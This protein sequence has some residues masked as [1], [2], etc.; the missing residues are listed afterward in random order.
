MQPLSC[1]VPCWVLGVVAMACTEV[2][3]APCPQ[4]C[5]RVWHLFAGAAAPFRPLPP[6]GGSIIVS[7]DGL[8]RL[9]AE[10]DAERRQRHQFPFVWCG[11]KLAEAVE[12]SHGPP[13]LVG[14]APALF[15]ERG[16][17]IDQFPIRW[18]DAWLDPLELL[19]HPDC[20]EKFSGATVRL[21]GADDAEHVVLQGSPGAGTRL[22]PDGDGEASHRISIAVSR[23]FRESVERCAV[24][25]GGEVSSGR[26]PVPC[27][28]LREGD[29]I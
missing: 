2:P 3:E 11:R 17:G 21:R 18:A 1:V 16:D 7:G 5:P 12:R 4:G 10:S 9:Q 8:L 19:H 20:S 24:V 6:D 14:S 15:G 26:L 23:V 28:G 13:E 22:P 29:G 27:D 25:G